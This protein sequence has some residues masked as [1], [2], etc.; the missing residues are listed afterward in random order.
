MMMIDWAPVNI[1]SVQ[2]ITYS[3]ADLD[4]NDYVHTH[5]STGI[6]KINTEHIYHKEIPLPSRD[7]LMEFLNNE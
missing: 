2:T 7:E 5:V 3:Y 1:S 6:W 4:T